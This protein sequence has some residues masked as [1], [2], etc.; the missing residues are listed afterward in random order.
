MLHR[1]KFV[2]AAG[3]LSAQRRNQSI[4]FPNVNVETVTENPPSVSLFMSKGFIWASI[5]GDMPHIT[6]FFSTVEC[7]TTPDFCLQTK[8]P[9]DC[10]YNAQCKEGSDFSL[11]IVTTRVQRSTGTV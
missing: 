3:A 6:H 5:K 2:K 4:Y 8:K 9:P 10:N 11:T 7:L 1:K